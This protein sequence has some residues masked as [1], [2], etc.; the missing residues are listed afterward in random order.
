ML[1][2]AEDVPGTRCPA[3][4]RGRPQGIPPRWFPPLRALVLLPLAAF[5]SFS[6]CARVDPDGSGGTWTP[7][8]GGGKDGECVDL[9]HD[10]HGRGCA[11]GAD[12][13][14][15]D[16]AVFQGC[17]A[18][19]NDPDN[20][21][22]GWGSADGGVPPETHDCP[23]GNLRI[24][25]KDLWSRQSSPSLEVF[26]TRPLAVTVVDKSW[27]EY[28]ARPDSPGCDWYTACVPVAMV[29]TIHLKALDGANACAAGNTSGGF[30][31]SAL[32]EGQDVYIDYA[33]T[34]LPVD[35]QAYPSVPIGPTAFRLDVDPAT[36]PACT[37]GEI[38]STKGFTKL[39]LRWP[40]GDPAV[41]GYAGSA[42]EDEKLG[43]STPPFPTSLR[44]QS[45]ACST[46]T[47]LLDYQGGACPWYT[48]LIP[49]E[50][51]QGSITLRY[52]DDAS[53]L[54]SPGIPLPTPRTADEYW[55]AYTGAPDDASNRSNCM[56]WSQRA[57]AFHFYTVNPGPGFA[58]CGGAAPPTTD[59]CTLLP[60]EDTTV[61]HFRYIWA[62]QKI[63]TYF[64][65]PAFMPN[66]IVLEVSGGGGDN[67][68]IC[69]RE[70][71]RPWYSCPVPN[72]KFKAGATWRAVDKTHDPEWNTVKPREFPATKGE[73]WITWFYGKPDIPEF[74]RFRF[75]NYNPDDSPEGDW[76]VTG[77]W[78]DAACKK[79]PSPNSPP[80]IGF[81]GAWFP[82]VKT[83]YQ[84]GY[85]GSLANWYGKRNAVQTLLNRFVWE[86]YLLWKENYVDTAN[87]CGPGTA[88]I[89]TDPPETVSEGQ[90][91]G[92][93]I[94]AAIGDKQL[95]DQLWK[96][97]RHYLSQSSDKYC[98]GL[99]GW[100]WQ[101]P[102]DCQ[103]LDQ[104]ATGAGI[105]DSAFDGDVDIAIAL[106]FAARQWPE[107][108][109]AA[110]SWLLKM[111]CE[112]NTAH[113]PRWA[114]PTPGDTWDKNCE[115]YPD[116]PCNYMPETNGMVNM[117]YYPPG[118]FR[119]FGEFLQANLK[120]STSAQRQSHKEFWYKA[121]STT[122][123]M[124]ERCYSADIHPALIADWGHY[125]TPCDALTG[126][127][128][129]S[130][131][132]WRL[133]VDAAWYGQDTSLPENK[134]RS[135]R[136]APTKSQIQAKMDLIQKFYADFQTKNPVVPHA[137]RFSTLCQNLT[138]TGLVTDCDPAYG[139]NSYF[140]NTAMC[141]YVGLFDDGGATNPALRQEALEEAVSTTIINDRY[142][143]ESIGVYTMLFLSG[144][145]PNPMRVP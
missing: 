112:I 24:H 140:V 143:Q 3:N 106:V 79:H 27:G 83:G 37:T 2:P 34:N 120:G 102:E 113:D 109:D 133:A 86:R 101:G 125:E 40:W 43:V 33:G 128:D 52:G 65:R 66:W 107:Y 32:K 42:C 11:A 70:A 144:N 31:L 74:S 93:A 59:P 18:V 4:L 20:P 54:Y 60:A 82:Y 130:R 71:D 8:G 96:F 137:N 14:D 9:D 28:A 6:G 87:A 63:F 139:H 131:S 58:G 90:G 56:N 46:G 138:P 25:V 116:K 111:E 5:I 17:V 19:G 41:T 80:P 81:P 48:I 98:G 72:S 50:K 84:Y 57:A 38:A 118:Y 100:M 7:P 122:W 68:V 39:H 29:S 16:P 62:G 64:P 23:K 94:A 76:G 103:P 15:Y 55:L 108:N 53:G 114:F 10:G 78:A 67:D 141:S 115:F 132:L 97:A 12:C 26:D 73:Y 88:R 110:I 124:V 30:D 127:Y 99:M 1:R 21:N 134:P 123:E 45:E 104:P 117:S 77:S 92:M 22:S 126:N 136:Y 36:P 85:G 145:F 51:W 47:A 61:V 105:H 75:T 95:F 121:A 89:K 135:S 35:Y 13:N 119:A 49:N 91:Y 69:W 44:V 142:Y 129:W